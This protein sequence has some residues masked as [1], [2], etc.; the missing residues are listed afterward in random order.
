MFTANENWVIPAGMD[1]R[2]F[3]VLKVADLRMGDDAYWAEYM[4]LLYKDHKNLPRN[5]EYLGRILHFFLSRKISHSLSRAMVTD[6]LVEQR[7]LTNADSMDA[8]FVLW[9]R[10]TFVRAREDEAEIEGA[11]KDFTFTVVTYTNQRWVVSADFY[12]DFRRYYARHHSK[13]RGFGTERDFKERLHEIGMFS[14]RV[15]KRSL[16]V[17]AG[18]YPGEPE[19]KITITILIRSDLLEE[20][21]AKRY[22]LFMELDDEKA[23]EDL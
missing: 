20:A 22:P 5:P 17:G 23:E 13:G 6:E 2:R 8:A 19:S 7:K 4:P 11:S 9:V 14:Q 1:S 21:L 3:L 16:K 18:K 12:T 15:K 10:Q